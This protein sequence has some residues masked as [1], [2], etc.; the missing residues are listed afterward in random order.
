MYLLEL[1]KY[2]LKCGLLYFEVNNE[3]LKCCV[4]CG[5]VYY[6]NFSVVIVVFILNDKNELLVCCRGKELVKGI[7]DLFGGFIDMYE[8]G[9]EGV[10]CEV[11]EEIGLQVEEVVYQ[12]LLF[13]IYFYLGFLV[14][15]LDQ[16]FFCKV[17]DISWIK[18][19]DDVVEFFWFFL[20]EVNF[21]EF[22]LD[23]VCEGVWC[24]LKEYKF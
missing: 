3:K 21:E 2:C 18:V 6:F 7:L 17:K 10:V 8:I 4:D 5:F 9:E 23:F 12:F 16:F 15:I 13:N 22:G 24:F 14:Y 20:D 19:M 1:F 11:L